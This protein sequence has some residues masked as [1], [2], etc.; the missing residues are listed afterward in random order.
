MGLREHD[1]VFTPETLCELKRYTE[2]DT[3]IWE[4]GSLFSTLLFFLFYQH[5]D[6][7]ECA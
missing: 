6:Q 7:P 2:F 5:S 4:S 3:F 1:G